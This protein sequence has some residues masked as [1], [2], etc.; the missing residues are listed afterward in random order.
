MFMIFNKQRS[1]NAQNPYTLHK[2][3]LKSYLKYVSLTKKSFNNKYAW[4]RKKKIFT[5]LFYVH[6]TTHL[7]NRYLIISKFSTNNG[8]CMY[9]IRVDSYGHIHSHLSS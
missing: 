9:D 1:N 8:K 2:P 3:I 6:N 7:L 5:P 4:Y